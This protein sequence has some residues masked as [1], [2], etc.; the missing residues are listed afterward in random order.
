MAATGQQRPELQ[1]GRADIARAEAETR[2]MRSM[3]APMGLVRLGYASTMA[4]GEGA[5]VMLGVSLPLWQGKRRGNVAE[6]VAMEEMA[7]VDL[8]AMQQMAAG[9]A[10][11]VLGELEAA[12]IDLR[13]LQEEVIPRASRQL[14]PA[15]SAYST[16]RGSLADVLNASEAFTNAKAEAIMGQTRLGLAWARLNRITGTGELHP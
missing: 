14:K 6:A 5:M 15:L 10:V 11:A 9:E 12:Q 13:T 16:G 2:V 8:E 4:D 7:R 3:N 1:A